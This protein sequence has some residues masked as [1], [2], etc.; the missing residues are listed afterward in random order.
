MVLAKTD[1]WYSNERVTCLATDAPLS[2]LFG[3]LETVTPACQANLLAN[4]F[5]CFLHAHIPY[6][7]MVLCNHLDHVCFR[8]I[9]ST[10][11][12]HASMLK[13]HPQGPWATMLFGFTAQ[14]PPMG[15]LGKKN[16]LKIERICSCVRR[17]SWGGSWRGALKSF[18]RLHHIPSHPTPTRPAPVEE[19]RNFHQHHRRRGIPPGGLSLCT[20]F[21]GTNHS[22]THPSRAPAPGQ[23]VQ[24]RDPDPI[25]HRYG[26]TR[27]STRW[28]VNPLD[29]EPQT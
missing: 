4:S 18:P 28:Q 1:P 17:G 15:T 10:I 21:S 3:K 20:S 11:L 5:N 7:T 27:R 29:S 25:Q 16:R 22:R 9:Q 6:R 24:P 8:H 19:A 2:H 23:M 26:S 12:D 13:I 14:C